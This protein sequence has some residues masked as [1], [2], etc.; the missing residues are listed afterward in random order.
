MPLPDT[1]FLW[2][3]ILAVWM[4]CTLPAHQQVANTSVLLWAFKRE[5]NK[6]SKQQ[7]CL[8]IWNCAPAQ[9]AAHT[10]KAQQTEIAFSK[11]IGNV[12]CV[13][14]ASAI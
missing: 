10:L 7:C 13:F 8:A 9:D 12:C 5:G 3:P 4:H 2:C 1:P 14:F 6:K 11:E